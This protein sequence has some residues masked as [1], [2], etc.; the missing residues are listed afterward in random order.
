MKMIKILVVENELLTAE[1]IRLCLNGAGYET[2]VTNTGEKAIELTA[3]HDYSVILMD[4]KL[5]GNID[6]IT[7]AAT[8]LKG[9]HVPII[10]IT[11]VEDK[12]IFR[13]VKD[14]QPEN[15]LI[16]PFP[17]DNA[18]LY[19]VELAIHKQ[20]Q[21]TDD[22]GELRVEHKIDAAFISQGGYNVKLNFDDILYIKANGAY[23]DIYYDTKEE[24]TDNY[25]RV[26]I[27]SNHVVEQLNYSSLMKINRSYYIN[28]KKVER[29]TKSSVF[30]RGTE[31]N[32]SPEH[33][34]NFKKRFLFFKH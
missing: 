33:N 15:Y 17:S 19:S 1:R 2:N 8:I 21:K 18:I 14:M 30:I 22:K 34:E 28:I 32:I 9:R 10:F 23:T 24:K 16:K 3:E 26:S 12:S 11:E 20:T 7:A 13:T 31:I 4:I 6:G 27:S 25:Y 29:T 5:D